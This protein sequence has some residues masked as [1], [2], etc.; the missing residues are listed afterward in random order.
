MIRSKTFGQDYKFNSLMDVMAKANEQSLE[1]NWQNSV[2][3][4]ERKEWQLKF[5]LIQLK[6]LKENPAVPYDEDEVTRIIIDGLN[7]KI[8]DEIKMDSWRIKR[9]AFKR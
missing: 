9:M 6:D 7:L 4:D 5:F 1:M 3:I 2:K 8:Y